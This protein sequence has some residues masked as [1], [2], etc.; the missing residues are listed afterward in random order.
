MTVSALVVVAV[1]AVLAVAWWTSREQRVAS[2]AVRGVLERVVLD[3]GDAEADVIG[4]GD[5]P[6]VRVRRVE[7]FA[8]AHPPEIQ[9]RLE[10]AVLRI[11]ARCPDA[12]FSPCHAAFQVVIPSNLPVTVRTSGGDVR[13]RDVRGSAELR[14]RSGAVRVEGFCGFALRAQTTSGSIDATTSCAPERMDLRTRSGTV[15]ATVPPG[16]YRITAASTSGRARLDRL[17]SAEDAPFQI[18][19]LSATGDVSVAARQ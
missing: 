6:V 2:F 10:G 4:G 8:F 1:G 7:E 18:Q 19:A 9:R 14:T 12:A 3:L 17:T 13:L 11:R 16:R 15:R 5:R